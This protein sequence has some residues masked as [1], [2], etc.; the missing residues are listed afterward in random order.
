MLQKPKGT[1]DLIDSE[2]R[3]FKYLENYIDRFMEIYNYSYIKVPTFEVS[4]LFKRGV[5]QTSD[6][7]NKE[8]YDFVDK[9]G[10]DMTLRPEFTAG[11]VRS[12]IENKQYIHESKKY[13]YFGSCFRYERPQN[14]RMREFTQVGIEHFGVKNPKVDAEIIRMSY[15]LLYGLGIE[16][17]KV[18]INTLGDEVSRENYKKELVKY[19]ENNYD[20]LC[21]ICKERFKK[22]P[23]RIL[24][25]KYDSER[26]YIKNS[27]KTIDHMN[28]DSINYFK[29]VKK[30]LDIFNVPYEVDTSLVRG[31]DY[32]SHTVFEIVVNEE[33]ISSTLIGGGRYD[34]L[35]SMLNGPVTPAIGFAMGVERVLNLIKDGFESEIDVYIM[36]LYNSD[37]ALILLNS[38]RDNGFV[39][40]ISYEN[41]NMKKE[42]KVVDKLKP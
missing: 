36:D 14:G 13:Y 28:S 2:A 17:I 15:M 6:I 41:K 29:E 9:G 21:D 26:E 20:N 1:N 37:E 8:T 11:V 10:R 22:N 27:P 33:E 24:D 23:L 5:G 40:E 38:L 19:L 16:N 34:A 12:F 18:K 39:T 35:V 25:C 7:V 3:K 32:Y 4:E 31:L 42:W 30:Y